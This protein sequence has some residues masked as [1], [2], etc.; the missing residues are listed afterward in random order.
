[1]L[2]QDEGREVNTL[3]SLY[4]DILDGK[5][6][7]DLDQL[8]EAL[9][10]R[11]KALRVQRNLEARASLCVGDRVTLKDLSPKRLNG[12]QGLIVGE[13]G[14]HFHVKLD[15]DYRAGPDAGKTVG[16]PP[17]CLVKS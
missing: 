1:M 10:V 15:D 7:E 11:D 5:H 3:A 6:D 13:G 4:G 9:R 16:I 14:R 12:C 8:F 2:R 17:G